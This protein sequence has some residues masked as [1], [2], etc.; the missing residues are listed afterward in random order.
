MKELCILHTN[1]R[2]FIINEIV[3]H[4]ANLQQISSLVCSV[5]LEIIKNTNNI[6]KDIG[7]YKIIITYIIQ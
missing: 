3:Y 2:I 5:S 6:L 1:A 4:I 7:S